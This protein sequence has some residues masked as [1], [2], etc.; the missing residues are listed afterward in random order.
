MSIPAFLAEAA[1]G[2]VIR[3]HKTTPTPNTQDRADE[4]LLANNDAPLLIEPW[5]VYSRLA[6]THPKRPVPVMAIIA[7]AALTERLAWANSRHA[8]VVDDVTKVYGQSLRANDHVALRVEPGAVY[9]LLGPNGAGKTTLVS[10]IIGLATP[11]SGT[12]TLGNVA[13]GGIDLVS[14]PAAARQLCSYLPQ[15]QLPIES[16]RVRTAIEMMGRIRGGDGDAVRKRT[17]TLIRT[18]EIGAWETSLGQS[19]SG[20]V[21]RLVG[22][23]MATVQPGRV[24]ILDEPTNDVDPLRRRLM[25]AEIRDLAA[26]G[27]AV[28]LVTHNVLEAERSVDR[29]ALIDEG[30]VIA[31]GTPASMKSADKGRL[32]LQATLEPGQEPPAPPPF[33]RSQTTVGRRYLLT[34][35]EPDAMQAIDWVRGLIDAGIAEEYELGATTLE[36][37]YVRLIGRDDSAEAEAAVAQ[38]T[39]A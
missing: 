14:N 26:Q 31:E 2:S 27:S 17:D 5:E 38:E 13:E 25:W 37:A 39:R 32:R 15:A 33:A 8:L 34:I 12:I 20:G 21:K 1:E 36:D 19:L 18:L 11:T 28:L 24:V 9:G 22:F 6:P 29:L 3:G 30:R 4:P 16:L 7:A 35:D 10:Q 23:I